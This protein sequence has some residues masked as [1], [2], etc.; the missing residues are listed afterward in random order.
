VAG[1]EAEVA[2]LGLDPILD[3][4]FL[5]LLILGSIR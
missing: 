3:P 2:A 1:A 5:N 4:N